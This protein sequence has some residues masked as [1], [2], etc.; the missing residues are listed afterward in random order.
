MPYTSAKAVTP[1]LN[2]S[3]FFGL[4]D[5]L[6]PYLDGVR[7]LASEKVGDE[8]CDKIEASIMNGQRTWYLWLSQRDHLPRKLQQIVRVS[9]KNVMDE[10]WSTVMVNGA[11]PKSMFEWHPPDDWTEW[12]RPEPDDLLLRPGTK[13]PD[14]DLTA[15]DGTRIKLSD[16]QGKVVWL[17]F[18]RCGCPPCREGMP[19][20]QHFHNKYKDHGLVVL[21]LN[22][23][24]DKQI[25]SNFMRDAGATFSTILDSSEAAQDVAW[26]SYRTT[27]VPVNYVL[28]RDG[29]VVDAWYGHLKGHTRETA[30]LKRAGLEL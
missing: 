19:D 16:Y 15:A 2:P 11:I 3:T 6:L 4:R 13:A 12:L 20:I 10:E 23:A 27:G 7:G 17:Y 22:E 21:G 30:A 24:D 18:W 8:L 26:K 14:F 9:G 1:I 5:S 28:D 29:K 25:A